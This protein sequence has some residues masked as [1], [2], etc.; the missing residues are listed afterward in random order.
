LQ[1]RLAG[2]PLVADIRGRGLLIGIELG[3]TGRSWSGK[4][5]PSMVSFAS[6]KVIG[7]WLALRLLEAGIVCQPATHAWNV[8]KIE[9]PLTIAE[10]EIAHAVAA[11]GDVFDEYHGLPKVLAHVSARL[12]RQALHRQ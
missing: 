3:P 11:I 7:Q 6:E 1:L 5:A 2:H 4:V 8:L 10:K 9:P 12:S